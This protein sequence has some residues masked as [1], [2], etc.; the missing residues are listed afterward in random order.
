MDV[1]SG[2]MVVRRPHCNFDAAGRGAFTRIVPMFDDTI[3]GGF[4]R[5]PWF[6]IDE[7]LYTRKLP[8]VL[9]KIRVESRSSDFTGIDLVSSLDQ[10]QELL[11]FANRESNQ[12]EII[13]LA[14]ESL[15]SIKGTISLAPNE[16]EWVGW[17]VAPLGHSSLLVEG[18]FARPDLF[19]GVRELV[20]RAGL[21]LSEEAVASYV[22]SYRAFSDRGLVEAVIEDPYSVDGIRIGRPRGEH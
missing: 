14:S 15:A 17:D 2:F 8:P 6:D 4:D 5:M 19:G 16:H 11:L 9:E 12:N 18:L 10:A 7:A 3:Y 21:L 20:N 13:T 1:V 22:Q